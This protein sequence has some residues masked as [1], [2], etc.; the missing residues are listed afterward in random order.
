M[1]ASSLA[2]LVCLSLGASA[3]TDCELCKVI[4][5][6]YGGCSPELVANYANKTG[7]IVEWICLKENPITSPYNETVPGKPIHTFEAA[8]FQMGGYTNESTFSIR[9]SK[10]L[11][12]WNFKI[13]NDT[14]LWNAIFNASQLMASSAS[15]EIYTTLDFSKNA[16][17]LTKND[18]FISFDAATPITTFQKTAYGYLV[19][20]SFISRTGTYTISG[21]IG[22]TDICAIVCTNP[23]DDY[24]SNI[25]LSG[26]YNV[27]VGNTF[28]YMD[29]RWTDRFGTCAATPD[30][31]LYWNRAG[32]IIPSNDGTVV[33]DCNGAVCSQ[34]NPTK[35][36]WYRRY[37]RCRLVGSSGSLTTS[38]VSKTSDGNTFSCVAPPTPSRKTLIT[39]DDDED[40]RKPEFPYALGLSVFGIMAV[41][42]VMAN[43]EGKNAA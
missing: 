16:T 35:T 23:A 6:I 29:A 13:I 15:F 34:K 36:T 39:E 37:P 27:L 25:A 31:V 4:T 2:L 33:L 21:T 30:C 1:R 32:A 20:T 12:A 14:I 8:N 9:L 42:Y 28:T 10:N 40:I 3:I 7:L 24:F 5:E 19:N 18:V 41:G 11:I 43:K 26:Q 38:F 22:K 17:T